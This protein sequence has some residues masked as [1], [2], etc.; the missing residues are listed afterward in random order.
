MKS[1]INDLIGKSPF[2]PIVEHTKK[3]HQ[4]VELF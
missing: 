3:V 2:G 4:S 1:L